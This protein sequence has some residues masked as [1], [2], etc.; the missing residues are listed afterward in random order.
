MACG[1]SA[2]ADMMVGVG[3]AS[4]SAGLDERLQCRLE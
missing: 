3:V 4:E 1:P 2:I